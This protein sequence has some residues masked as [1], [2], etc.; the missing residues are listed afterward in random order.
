MLVL[1]SPEAGPL[2][3]PTTPRVPLLG[4]WAGGVGWL[5][6]F[7]IGTNLSGPIG[8]KHHID[9]CARTRMALDMHDRA[10]SLDQCLTER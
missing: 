5:Q 10:V 6:D 4:G 7:R 1:E 8:W 9:S 2:P 3:G